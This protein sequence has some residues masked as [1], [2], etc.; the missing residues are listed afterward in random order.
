MRVRLSPRDRRALVVCAVAIGTILMVGR[1][2]P[3]L[4]RWESA[5]EAS[6]AE[7]QHEVLRAE[8]GL[9]RLPSV[10]D[11]L[12]ARGVRLES[13][14]P[15]LFG[16]ESPDAAASA[17]ASW[18]SR[19]A[20]RS[21]SELGALYVET[22]SASVGVFAPVA[23]RGDLVTDVTGLTAFLLEVERGPAMLAVRQLT[24]E[25]P[26][27]GLGDGRMER[28]HVAFKVEGLALCGGILG[29]QN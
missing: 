24:I 1:G 28:L 5:A 11:S 2:V 15:A 7:I 22:D 4:L 20:A 29:E 25:Q 17:L 8:I 6:A 21:S 23:V 9:V 26:E 14:G 27:P 13:I 16:G 10:L 19:V 3:A 18:L 12:D